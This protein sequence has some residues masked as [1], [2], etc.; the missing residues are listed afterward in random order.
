MKK[1]TLLFIAA[2]GLTVA[3]GADQTLKR[4]N[5]LYIIVDDQSPLISSFIIKEASWMRQSSK[6][7]RLRAW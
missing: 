2:L 7:W 5:I 4:P 6:N 1:L 3:V